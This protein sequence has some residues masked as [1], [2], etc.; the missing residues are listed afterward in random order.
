MHAFH[1]RSVYMLDDPG[2]VGHRQ[3]HRLVTS[4]LDEKTYPAHTL[5]VAYHERWEIEI[6]I[7]E[8]DTHQRRPRQPL[9]SRTPLGVL[10]E[11]Y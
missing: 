5:A 8:T 3:R 1:F 2:R 6:T 7:D 10:Q 11:L 9:R 4:L